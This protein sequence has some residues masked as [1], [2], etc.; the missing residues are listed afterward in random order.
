MRPNTLRHI[1][2]VAMGLSALVVGFFAYISVA[3]L[4]KAEAGVAMLGG[5]IVF[6]GALVGLC[7][8]EAGSDRPPSEQ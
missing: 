1:C 6:A 2:V 7:V 5:C 3:K 4:Y 8:L